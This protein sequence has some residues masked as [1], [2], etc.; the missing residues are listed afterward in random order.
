MEIFD[1]L[2]E[3]D[4]LMRRVTSMKVGG[5]ATVFYTPSN[6][7][8]LI[9]RAAAFYRA[10]APF[11]IFGNGTNI[12]VRD[13]G[14]PGAVISTKQAL[15]GIEIRDNN[16]IVCGAGESLVR[17]CRFAAEHS[18]S[19]MEALSGIPGTVG[20]AV[21]M[22]AGA[23]GTEISDILV[24]ARVYSLADKKEIMLTNKECEFSYRTSVF[25]SKPTVLLSVELSLKPDDKENIDSE[26]ADF[27]QK[28]NEKQPVDMPSVGSF[29]KRPAGQ[30]AGKLIE[31]AGMKG[32]RVGGAQVSKKHSGFI[33]NLGNATADDV[34]KLSEEVK[35][36]VYNR[37][38]ITLEEEPIVIGV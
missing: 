19:G 10:K 28:R 7:R 27:L 38:N 16:S 29:F 36:Q 13:H 9:A 24:S 22:N 21:F 6:E 12:I 8:G 37:F 4:V 11:I 18:L 14:Y 20:G 26:M 31:E 33:V 35:T 15:Q 34:L 23:Y 1:S 5:L 30:F 32:E 2:V 17:V 25:R 3:Y